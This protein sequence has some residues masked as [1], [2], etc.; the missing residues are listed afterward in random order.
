MWINEMD[1][2]VIERGG[3]INHKTWLVYCTNYKTEEI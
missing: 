2:Q 1:T 3:L